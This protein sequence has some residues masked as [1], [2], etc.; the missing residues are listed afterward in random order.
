MGWLLLLKAWWDVITQHNLVGRYSSRAGSSLYFQL[1]WFGCADFIIFWHILCWLRHIIRHLFTLLAISPVVVLLLLLWFRTHLWALR[2]VPGWRCCYIC[3]LLRCSWL[4]CC[5]LSVA[6]HFRIILVFILVLVELILISINIYILFFLTFLTP[7]VHFREVVHRIAAW[8]SLIWLGWSYILMDEILLFLYI[9]R[10]LRSLLSSA[11]CGWH[12]VTWL[13]STAL[14]LVLKIL[15]WALLVW[16]IF[17]IWLNLV[18]SVILHLFTVWWLSSIVAILNSLPIWCAWIL[19]GLVCVSI[20]WIYRVSFASS[21][22]VFH[23]WLAIFRLG[24]SSKTRGLR[25]RCQLL[26][27]TIFGGA[28]LKIIIISIRV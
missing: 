6:Q 14:T 3:L 24:S 8:V 19:R 4:I 1:I 27:W 23:L 9:A 7:S 10:W 21:P 22:H 2:V 26:L 13:W 28:G 18:V 15:S 20:P 12:Y 16:V 5:V 11:T 25:C 17:I